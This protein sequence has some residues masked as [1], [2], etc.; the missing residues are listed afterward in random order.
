MKKI[1]IILGSILLT[2]CSVRINNYYSGFVVDEIGNPISEVL[3]C[4]CFIID[5]CIQNENYCDTTDERGYFYINREKD[6]LHKLIFFKDGYVSDTIPI[7]WTQ[8][9]ETITYSRLVTSDSSGII[10]QTQ[11]IQNK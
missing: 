1:V 8:S 2:A 10:M 11:S 7:V 3:V 9:G 5:N 6:L 4:K